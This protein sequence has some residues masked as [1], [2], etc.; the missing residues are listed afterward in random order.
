MK[1]ET[2]VKRYKTIGY[3][4]LGLERDLEIAN[5]I[6][7]IYEKYNIYIDVIMC[8]YDNKVHR[9]KKGW[10][11]GLKKTLNN[12][13]YTK[14]VYENPFDAKFE[15]VRDSIKVIKFQYQ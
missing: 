15:M 8:E 6:K 9:F 2:L 10:F 7:W 14:K 11:W 4:P 13:F 5:I 3:Q 12:S 1:L